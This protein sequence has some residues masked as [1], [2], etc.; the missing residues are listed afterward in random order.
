MKLLRLVLSALLSSGALLGCGSE[1]LSFLADSQTNTTRY[2]VVLHHG[3]LGFDQILFID[4][5][6]KIRA[7][8]EADGHTVRA[9]HVPTVQSIEVRSEH[10]GRQIDAIL[11]ETEASKVNIIAHSLGGLDARHVISVMGYG[12]RVASVITLGTPHRGTPV[13]DLAFSVLSADGR[14]LLTALERLFLGNKKADASHKAMVGVNLKAALWSLSEEHT[15]SPDFAAAHQ[16]DPRVVYESFSGQ[17]TFTGLG[18][19]DRVHPLLLITHAYLRATIGANDGLVPLESARYGLDRGTLPADHINLIG[20]LFGDTSRDF[21]YRQFY[22][23][24][25]FNLAARGF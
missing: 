4:Y 21:N 17:S 2:P 1:T 20:Q 9:T 25:A 15:R 7:T 14:R 8:L 24:L 13:A 19:P 22:R 16:D 6:Y 23:D 12:D 5:F 18:Q 11:A 3:L 10:L